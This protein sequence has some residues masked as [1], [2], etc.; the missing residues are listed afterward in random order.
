MFVSTMM[1]NCARYSNKT[2]LIMNIEKNKRMMQ[3]IEKVE[4]L[5]KVAK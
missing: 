3:F 5:K 4:L 2:N 1:K